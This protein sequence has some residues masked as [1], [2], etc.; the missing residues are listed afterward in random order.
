VLAA[1]GIRADGAGFHV[2]RAMKRDLHPV[3]FGFSQHLGCGFAGGDLL[4]I[5]ALFFNLFLNLLSFFFLHPFSSFVDF[6]S[7]WEY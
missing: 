1:R 2:C 4:D 7:F 3:P 6:Y 5:K